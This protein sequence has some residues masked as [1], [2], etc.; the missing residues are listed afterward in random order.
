MKSILR[1]T[2]LF[3]AVF[4]SLINCD[5]D[6]KKK[7]N[8]FEKVNVLQNDIEKICLHIEQKSLERAKNFVSI[9]SDAKIDCPEKI[10]SKFSY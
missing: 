6:E 9:I 4:L 7:L 10:A 5:Q 3:L 1:L 2:L 8:F